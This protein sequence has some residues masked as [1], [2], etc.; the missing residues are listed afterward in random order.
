MLGHTMMACTLTCTRC[1]GC[2]QGVRAATRGWAPCRRTN[3]SRQ[4]QTLTRNT[5]IQHDTAHNCSTITIP[6]CYKNEMKLEF[7]KPGWSDYNNST[8][9]VTKREGF[10]FAKRK[11]AG[12]C[13]T[14]LFRLHQRHRFYCNRNS[15]TQ[16]DNIGSTGP[17]VIETAGRSRVILA[18]PVLLYVRGVQRGLGARSGGVCARAVH[19][20]RCLWVTGARHN[21]HHA[22]R[23]RSIV[24]GGA[25][26]HIRSV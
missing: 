18:A 22:P 11:E 14:R 1:L 5:T 6:F 16:S 8:A 19:Y 15:R 25:T 7:V 17:I 3:S 21:T 20:A 10:F 9:T 12:V 26:H 24:R 23:T 4:N 2:T 13:E